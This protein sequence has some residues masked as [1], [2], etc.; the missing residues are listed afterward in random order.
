MDGKLALARA[1]GGHLRCILND[2]GDALFKE[3][4]GLIGKAK[5]IPAKQLYR[6]RKTKQRAQPPQ[7]QHFKTIKEQDG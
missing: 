4:A 3:V 5:Q 7:E 1:M 6:P 2:E